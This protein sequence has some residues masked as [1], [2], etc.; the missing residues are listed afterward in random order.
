MNV[1]DEPAVSALGEKRADAGISGAAR[2]RQRIAGVRRKE[3]GCRSEGLGVLLDIV[4]DRLDPA[5]RRD[6]RH[7]AVCVGDGPPQ[8]VG[9]IGVDLARLREMIEG[10]GFVEAA[11]LHRP[12]HR[13]SAATECEAA[14]GLARDRPHA[15]IDLRREHA[16]DPHLRLAHRLAPFQGRIIQEWKAHR[17]LDLEHPVP[18]EEH[19]RRMGVDAPDRRPTMGRRVGQQRE[20]R[21]LGVGICHWLTIDLAYGVG[22][23]SAA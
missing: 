12:L 19:R 17:A 7:R 15:A 14:V 13:G 16:V 23:I 9:E 6:R 3:I 8:G 22:R 4:S 18:G 10:C 1:P 5:F 11:H 2:L 21:F 20:Y